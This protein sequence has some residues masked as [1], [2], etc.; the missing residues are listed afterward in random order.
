MNRVSE[1]IPA[2]F[3]LSLAFKECIHNFFRRK[4]VIKVFT[5]LPDFLFKNYKELAKLILKCHNTFEKTPHPEMRTSIYGGD[6]LS[7]LNSLEN[8]QITLKKSSKTLF[9]FTK[10]NSL[11]AARDIKE[12][13]YFSE[14]EFDRVGILNLANR[15]QAGGVGLA[16][17][18][19]SQE[20]YLIRRSNLA[21]ALDPR[22]SNSVHEEMA[23]LRTKENYGNQPFAHHIPYFGALVTRNVT[24]IDKDE[25]DQFDVI[26]SAAP[27]L[28]KNSDEDLHIKK[29]GAEAGEAR[30]EILENKIRAI[31]ASAVEANI[32]HLV[33]GAYGCGC[34]LNDS[35]EVAKIFYNVL[36][37][38]KY[39]NQFSTIC[40]AI[41]EKTKLDI[42]EKVF[43]DCLP[44]E[45]IV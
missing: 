16:P 34:F 20:E 30:K 38:E 26:S 18:G 40:F 45:Q 32:K 9:T 36:N 41:T 25:P 19:G 27:D 14:N 6:R 43:K 1:N 29:F 22:F 24:F 3:N 42:F 44:P 28:R 2:G 13:L 5:Y 11:E 35:E 23:K 4:F 12:E 10:E 8:K 39:K 31:F 15:R 21:W 37:S 33:L 17:Y 7:T